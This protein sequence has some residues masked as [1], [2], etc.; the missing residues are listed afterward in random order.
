MALIEKSTSRQYKTTE[1]RSAKIFA[2]GGRRNDFQNGVILDLCEEIYRCEMRGD[3]REAVELLA[4]YW[5]GFDGEITLTSLNRTEAANL[6]LRIGSVA[7]AFGNAEQ[8][9]GS[10]EKSRGYLSRAEDLFDD[11]GDT[12]GKAQCQN[13]TGIAYWRNGDL[14][15]AQ[16]YFRESLFY[17]RSDESKAIA[18]LNIAMIE[19][20]SFRYSS[21]LK[22]YEKAYQ[23]IGRISVFTEAK[24][25]NGIGLA[26]KD[27][28]KN[29][30][31]SERVTYFDKAI[32]EFEGALICYEEVHNSRSAILARNNIG[33]LYYSIGLY[34]EAVRIL[35]IAESKARE[36][37]DK[38]HL[39]VVSD[40]LARA[41]IAKGNYRR[42]IEI[43]AASVSYLESFENSNLLAT[44][45]ITY[46]VALARG[47]EIERAKSAF[48]QAEEVASFIQD[49]VLAHAS[50][51]FALRELFSEYEPKERLSSY[52]YAVKHLSGSQEKD[53]SD[54][55]R[56]VAAKIE[57][58]IESPA[59]EVKFTTKVKKEPLLLFQEPFSLDE[60]LKII[61]R[62]YLEAAI[63][64]SG[65]NQSRA[66]ALLGMSRQTFAARV[67]K[68]FPDLLSS[69]SR[70]DKRS[71]K[72]ESSD[73]DMVDDKSAG[74]AANVMDEELVV[75]EI[76]ADY[77]EIRRGDF[78]LVKPGLPDANTHI[79]IGGQNDNNVKI[80]F[81]V[82]NEAGYFLESADGGRF[83]LNE[84]GRNSIIGEVKG[85][86]RR[87]EFQEYLDAWDEGSGGELTYKTLK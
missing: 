51:L 62:E 33:Y 12:E 69:F 68:D 86:C 17:A 76:Q 47:G 18:N 57:R 58:E 43:A 16:I 35:E 82:K 56:E 26:Y 25:R 10:Q 9:R 80:G 4:P 46:G 7:S 34:D 65:G 75:T 49:F 72:A 20:L 39:S 45:L 55:L 40:T 5:T 63:R 74:Y 2:L 30:S 52:F 14:D 59:A 87:A 41:F 83:E 13:K 78:L 60:Q 11:L 54:A 79:I 36:L 48:E 32:I 37:Q 38:N 66:A 3:L 84:A 27:I 81:F 31:G 77:R 19:S 29:H 70:K 53:I 24:I 71:K 6:L 22:I 67:K 8:I 50:R 21:A 42:A 1:E 15:T 61:S 64:E 28:G 73:S 23:F 85:F 44:A